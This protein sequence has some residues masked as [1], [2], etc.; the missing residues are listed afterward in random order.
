M[1]PEFETVNRVT[2]FSQSGNVMMF[3]I[4]LT[5]M[6]YDICT[7]HCVLHREIYIPKGFIPLKSKEFVYLRTE[8]VSSWT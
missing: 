3:L 5:D 4:S 2:S 1:P 7:M 6:P 8:A